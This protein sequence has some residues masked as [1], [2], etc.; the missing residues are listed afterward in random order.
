MMEGES[1]KMSS[2]M[3]IDISGWLTKIISVICTL[4]ILIYNLPRIVDL[5]VLFS[6]S[7][8]FPK[9]EFV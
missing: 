2:D 9:T 4:Q 7:F 8:Y 5:V 3:A 1:I 6:A